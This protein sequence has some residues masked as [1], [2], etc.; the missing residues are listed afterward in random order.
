MVDLVDAAGVLITDSG[1]L[2]VES[3]ALGVP[4]L[5]VRDTTEWPETIECGANR[6][7]FDPALLPDAARAAVRYRR[8]HVLK[9]GTAKRRPGLSTRCAVTCDS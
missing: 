8:G 6:L 5:T 9:G 2:Q 1:G 7:V 3:A 4:C